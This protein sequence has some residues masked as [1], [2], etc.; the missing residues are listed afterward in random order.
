MK[1]NNIKT[2]AFGLALTCA[3]PAMAQNTTTIKGTVVD[4]NGDPVIGATIHVPGTRQATVT[5]LDGNYSISAPKGTTLTVTYVG[6][7]QISTKGGRIMLKEGDTDLDEVVVVGYGTQKRAH[8]TGSVESIPVDEI[9]DISSGN[10]AS[11]LSGLVNGLSVSGGESQPGEAARITIRTA[12]TLGD[13]GSTVQQP[14]FVIDGY[15]YPNDVKVGN[16]QQNL[17]AEAFNNLDPAEIESISVLKDASAAV[18]GARAANGVIL[19]TTKKGKMGKPVISYSGQYGWTDAVATP[20]MLSAYN[21]GRLYNEIAARD[22]LNTTLDHTTGLFQADELEAMKG[23]NNDLLDKYWKTG[24]TQKHSVNIS[25]ASDR[26]NYFAGIGY[27]DQDGNLGRLDYNRWNYRAGVD[28]KISK[29]LGAGVTISGDYGKRNTGNVKVGGSS[30][31]KQ[32]NLLLTR[33]YYLPEYI[34]ENDEYPILNY[35]PTNSEAN[36]NQRYNYDL[37]INDGDYSKSMTSNLNIGANINYDFGWSKA[38]KGLKVSFQYSKSINTNKGNEYGSNFT[39]YNMQKRYGSGSHLYSPLDGSDDYSLWDLT[40]LVAHKYD[41]GNYLARTDVRTDN[42]QMNFTVNYARDFGLHNVQAL[43]SIEKSEAESEYQRSSVTNPYEFTTGQSNS[44]DGT[45]TGIFTRSESGSLSYIGRVNYSYAG[46]YLFEFLM[47]ADASQKFSPENRWGYF[48]AT[49]IGW[50]ASEEKW[51]KKAMPWWN[52]LKFRASFGL[53]GRDNTTAWQWMQVYAQ[54]KNRGVLFG[55]YTKDTGNRITINKNN[56]AVNRD[57]TWDKSYKFNFG[58]DNRF[59]NNRLSVGL[60]FYREW[61]RD[62]LINILQVVPSTV[63][64]QSAASNNGEID[65]WGWELSL[66]WRDKIGKD[67]KY[68]IG[69]NTG[70]SDN[71]V[72]RMDFDQNFYYRQIQRNGRTDIGTW[73]MQ[74]IGMFRSFQDIDEY[75]T[76]YHITSYMGMSK[77]QVRPG[78]LIYKDVRGSQHTDANGKIYYDGPDGIV[79]RDNDQVQLGHRGNIYGFTLNAGGSWKGLSFQLQ[80]GAHWGGYTTVPA[81]ALTASA[82][83]YTNMP[84]FWNPDN[85]FVYQNVYDGQG[86]LIQAANRNACLPNPGYSI[87]T[88]ASSFW[89]ISAAQ[90]TLNR[91]TLAYSLPKAWLKSLGIGIQ[92]VRLN[93]TGQNLINFYNPYPDNFYSPYAGTYGNY[94]NL[95]KWTL[96]V[97]V[98]F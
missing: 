17:G 27:F 98:S 79:D 68:N 93:L 78:M 20:K 41:N 72:L 33:P 62:M 49:S 81:Q 11:T 35:G 46:R 53:T 30:D 24:F 97:N 25:G 65:N 90:V 21:Y 36:Q 13:I 70:Y 59:L 61:N 91:L 83:E 18:Y 63:G 71:K 88:V 3:I 55:D 9:Q 89:R 43:F 39:I 10:L 34:G 16:V 8:L 87:N 42:Y 29:W 76:K 82:I 47:R 32:Y 96:G 6:Y 56:S 48:P 45:Q 74:C 28:V 92:N 52:F 50:I 15:I 12:N 19:V 40:N 66:G 85:V 23:M 31:Q 37:L 64:T 44:A 80:F 51:F 1:T 2:L 7:K 95:R 38:L 75:F 73:G 5:D 58:I 67:F 84:S 57:I 94:P 22:P 54:D 69:I 4:E 14:L 60:D 86:N 77:D 26:V